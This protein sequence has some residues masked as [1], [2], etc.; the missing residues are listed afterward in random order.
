MQSIILSIYDNI[1]TIYKS[2]P[3]IFLLVNHI[4]ILSYKVNIIAFLKRLQKSFFRVY[5][6]IDFFMERLT[7]KAGRL[8]TKSL[9]FCLDRFIAS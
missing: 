6:F 7:L 9:R 5:Q 2:R 3:L 8:L 4:N 1:V